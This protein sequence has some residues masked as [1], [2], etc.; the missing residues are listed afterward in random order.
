MFKNYYQLLN[1]SPNATKEE[2]KRAYRLYVFKFHPDK[3][4]NDPFF[5][6]RFIEIQEAFEIL[7]DE[8]K[9]EEYDKKFYDKINYDN[10]NFQEGNPIANI[11]VSS[12]FIDFGESVTF[13]WK[14]ENVSELQILNHGYYSTNGKVIFSPERTS[15]YVFLFSNGNKTLKEEFTIQVK[16]KVG[17]TVGWIFGVIGAICFVS[18]LF[19]MSDNTEY[20]NNTYVQSE[21]DSVAF[22]VVD[23]ID[24]NTPNYSNN[25]INNT[26][27][28]NTNFNL[29]ETTNN[30]YNSSNTTKQGNEN[31]YEAKRM[32]FFYELPYEWEK[33]E[34]YLERG[35]IV[36][37]LSITGE[38]GFVELEDEQGNTFGGW[39]K[40]S[41]FSKIYY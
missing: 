3:H 24:Y 7:F 12:K 32:A 30:H 15:E 25:E 8:G 37:L 10:N 18:L 33:T 9:R 6:E 19:I 5:K 38:F 28:I 2:I 11:Q 14:T 16:R 40:M 23:D 31:L 13:E 1:I 35:A 34:S 41:D 21:V 29:P 39:F 26:Q 17:N 27:T 22:E 36:E 4:Q 20:S